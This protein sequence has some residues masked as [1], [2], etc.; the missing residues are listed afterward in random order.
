MKFLKQSTAGQVVDIGPVTTDDGKTPYTTALANTEIKVFKHGAGAL[1]N[2]NSGGSTHMAS[3]I[4]AATFDAVDTDTLGMFSIYVVV[5]GNLIY[6]DSYR[7][8][9][10]AVYDALHNGTGNGLRA[11]VAAMQAGVVTAAAVATGAIDADALAADAS[12]EIVTALAGTVIEPQGNV[13]FKSILQLV[14]AAVAGRSDTSGNRFY[15]PN[16][17]AVRITATTNASGER[18]AVT[19][20]PAA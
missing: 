10:A 14:L 15:S 11:D 5:A 4:H 1:V 8:V 17:G 19:I 13:T 2:K 12:T 9:P 16:G 7:V 3:G 18:T 6:K 20:S